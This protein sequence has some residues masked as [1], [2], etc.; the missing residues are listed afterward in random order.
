MLSSWTS[1]AMPKSVTLHI[2]PSPINTL[3]AARSRW[4]IYSKAQQIIDVGTTWEDARE[5]KKELP[6]GSVLSKMGN[7]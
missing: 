1:L 6:R 4:I 5:L 2:S 3:R 7:L